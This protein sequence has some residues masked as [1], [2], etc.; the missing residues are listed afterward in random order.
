[1][2]CQSMMIVKTNIK[3]KMRTYGDKAYANF[4]DLN[5]PEDN[6]ESGSITVI[7]IDPLLL[8][9]NKYYLKA[10]LDNC[11][12]KIADKRTIDYFLKTG[13]YYFLINGFYKCCRTIE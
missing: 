12:Y 5:M 10:Y 13:E 2:L 1:M 8:C 11:A 4:R 9:K 6:I 7:S 3:T